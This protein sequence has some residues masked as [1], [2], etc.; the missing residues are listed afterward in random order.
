MVSI[1]LTG[2]YGF[3]NLLTLVLCVVLLDDASIRKMLRL[4]INT[5]LPKPLSASTRASR[6][7]YALVCALLAAHAGIG[8]IRMLD[9][10]GVRPD[11]PAPIRAAATRTASLRSANSYGL[12]AVMTT[13]RTE[14]EIEGSRDGK[15]WRPYRFSWKPGPRDRAPGFAQP[16]MPRLDWQMWFAALGQ[17][18]TNP[19]FVRFQARLLEGSSAVSALLDDDPFAGEPPRYIRST[20]H[21]YRFAPLSESTDWW[22]TQRLGE[23]CP[24]LTLEGT[25]LKRVRV[26]ELDSG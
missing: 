19:W 15:Q 4:E 21:R 26:G 6:V 2:N 13:D 7:G 18:R 23:Y 10:I 20:V 8:S 12:F 11:W 25:Q 1:A 16:H 14:I 3:F 5:C 9:R 22:Q 17:C 24:V